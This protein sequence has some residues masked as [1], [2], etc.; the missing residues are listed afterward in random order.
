MKK[1]GLQARVR[2]TEKAG[3]LKE[4]CKDASFCVCLGLRNSFARFGL[5]LTRNITTSC[6]THGQNPGLQPELTQGLG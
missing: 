6:E 4:R 3:W 2:T 1:Q 5:P